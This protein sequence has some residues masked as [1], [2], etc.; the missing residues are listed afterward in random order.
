MTDI[1]VTLLVFA[2]FLLSNLYS[3]KNTAFFGFDY[4][5]RCMGIYTPNPFW[6]ATYL[7]TRPFAIICFFETVKVL[8]E[9][10]RNFQW[11][12][13]TLFAVSLLLTTMTKPSFTMVVV[14]LIGLI[15][16]VQLIVSRGESFRNAFRLCVTMIPTGIALLYQFSGDLLTGT[17]CAMGEETGIAIGFAKVWSNYSKSI[18]LKYYYGNG[19]AYWC[20]FPES[21]V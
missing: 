5:Y 1:V 3:P 20:P 8:S 18:P 6:N 11:K 17:E 19:I 13:C 21:A 4:A 9:Y 15:L 2:L 7:A 12:N 16:L 14:P 10:Q